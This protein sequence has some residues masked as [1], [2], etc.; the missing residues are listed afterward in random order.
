[1]ARRRKSGSSLATA[2]IILLCVLLAAA[3]L[4]MVIFSRK[5]PVDSTNCLMAQAPPKIISV[6]ID[7]S[8]PI[9]IQ[10]RSKIIRKIRTLVKNEL[11]VH[12]KINIYLSARSEDLERNFS[13][14]NPGSARDLTFFGRMRTNPFIENLKFKKFEKSLLEQLSDK[15]LGGAQRMSPLLENI[16]LI[17]AKDFPETSIVLKNPRQYQIVLIS[18][19]LQNS[20]KVS[21]FKK[22]PTVEKIFQ[23][24]PLNYAGTFEI[25]EL[26]NIKYENFQTDRV[27][28]VWFE[29]IRDAGGILTKKEVW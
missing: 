14:C 26:A 1:M 16:D 6:Y 19:L 24:I 25:H 17:V 8:D 29:L 3:F 11:P 10:Q 9:N 27:R 28:K 20:E 22:I 13:E 5:E 7:V 12:G 21:F 4:M 2:S 23:S 15:N 18:D